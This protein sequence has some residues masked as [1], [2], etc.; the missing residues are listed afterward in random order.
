M[1]AVAVPDRFFVTSTAG[2]LPSREHSARGQVVTY[3]NH[4]SNGVFVGSSQIGEW[5]L[6]QR[7][8]SDKKIF[9]VASVA[10]FS[11]VEFEYGNP[12]TRRHAARVVAALDAGR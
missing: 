9:P 7:N 10:R 6:V 3:P 4:P 8:Y 11:V 12:V 5:F 2:T 1:P